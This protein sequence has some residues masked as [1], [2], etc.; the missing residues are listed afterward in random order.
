MGFNNGSPDE[1]PVHEVCL[2]NYKIGKYEVTQALWQAVM[3]T[4][5]SHFQESPSHPVEMVTWEDTQ[6][7]IDKLNTITGKKYRLPTEAEWEYACLSGGK[8]EKFCGSNVAPEVAWHDDQGG[9]TTKAVGTKQPNSLGI[10]DMSGN[11]EEWASDWYDPNYYASSPVENPTGP[12]LA[13]E[14]G[15]GHVIRGGEWHCGE[16]VLRA[17]NRHTGGKNDRPDKDRGFRLAH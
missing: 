12:V 8:D 14:H 4:N 16:T 13:P 3:G 1:K 15:Q 17:R 2:D 10:Y 7:F 6:E 5:P 11:V 9:K